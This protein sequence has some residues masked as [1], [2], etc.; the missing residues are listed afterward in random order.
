MS[1]LCFCFF[2]VKPNEIIPNEIM[3]L[4]CF[5]FFFI[6]PQSNSCPHNTPNRYSIPTDVCSNTQLKF[7][8]CLSLFFK[9][10][11]CLQQAALVIWSL[12][13]QTHLPHFMTLG[14][15]PPLFC[16]RQG[17]LPEHPGALAK[18]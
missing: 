3:S 16:H 2:C 10:C 1:L 9:H 14:K 17:R 5:C 11:K 7:L 13:H 12:S 4:F 6:N 18:A 8:M 15:S